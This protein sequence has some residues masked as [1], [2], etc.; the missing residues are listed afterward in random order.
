MGVEPH[1][2]ELGCNVCE[3]EL[4]VVPPCFGRHIKLS[5]PIIIFK[6]MTSGSKTLILSYTGSRPEHSWKRAKMRRINSLNKT[7]L[8]A[9]SYFKH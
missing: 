8:I 6:F 9:K 7:C 1:V 5:V 3:R 2:P 4:S